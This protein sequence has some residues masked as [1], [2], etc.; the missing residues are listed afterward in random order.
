MEE[1]I[2]D[3]LLKLFANKFT[4]QK[5]MTELKEALSKGYTLDYIDNVNPQ[6]YSC[7]VGMSHQNHT[8]FEFFF[9]STYPF[10]PPYIKINGVAVEC[11]NFKISF[12]DYTHQHEH[13]NYCFKCNSLID[14][15]RWTVKCK[16]CDLLNE[17]THAKLVE[18]DLV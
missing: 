2:N 7:E 1:L 5:L 17:L 13:H 18:K 6:L 15:D 14:P 10:K 12:D 4:R 16:L 8:H 3:K 9:P 11:G